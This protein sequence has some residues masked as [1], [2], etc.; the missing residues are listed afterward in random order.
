MS[1]FCKLFRCILLLSG[2]LYANHVTWPRRAPAKRT[3]LLQPTHPHLHPSTHPQTYTRARA[4]DADGNRS[5]NMQSAGEE[6]HT[7]CMWWWWW[8]WCA[9]RRAGRRGFSFSH[10]ASMRVCEPVDNKFTARFC[11]N[12]I[13]SRFVRI[14]LVCVCVCGYFGNWSIR[15]GFAEALKTTHWWVYVVCLVLVKQLCEL[16]IVLIWLGVQYAH[17]LILLS[18]PPPHMCDP[19]DDRWHRGAHIPLVRDG[20]SWRRLDENESNRIFA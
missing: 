17:I 13:R 6:V 20:C 3:F 7:K 1:L 11:L 18:A 4:H 9:V 12:W 14:F 16:R 10:S 2:C 19:A 5:L 15:R 8:W